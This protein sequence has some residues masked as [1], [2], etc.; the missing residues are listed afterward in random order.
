MVARPE[1]AAITTPLHYL[2]GFGAQLQLCPDTP[3][4]GA[5]RRAC[6]GNEHASES[7]PGTLPV[8][9]NNPQACAEGLYAEQLS[10]AHPPARWGGSL[11]AVR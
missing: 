1:G 11:R 9:Q 3:A 7:V 2:T 5:E 10:G 8:G 4:A 6:A